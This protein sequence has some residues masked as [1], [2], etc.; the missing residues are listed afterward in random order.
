MSIFHAGLTLG[1]NRDLFLNV[2][3]FG[4]VRVHNTPG[5]FYMGNL[6]G[7]RHQVIHQRCRDHDLVDVPGLGRRSITIMIRT[8]LFPTHGADP[9]A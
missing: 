9:K 2:E 1:G 5:T 4:R 7:P 8:G 3:G 6:T